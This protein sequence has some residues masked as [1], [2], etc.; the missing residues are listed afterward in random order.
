MLEICQSSLLKQSGLIVRIG[1][2]NMIADGLI[3]IPVEVTTYEFYVSLIDVI[4]VT[5]L[6]VPWTSVGTEKAGSR[7]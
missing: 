3:V 1:K 7:L 2:C 4:V 5:F 6:H